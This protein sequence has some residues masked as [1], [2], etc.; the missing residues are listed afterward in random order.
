MSV[1]WLTPL[2]LPAPVLSLLP[3]A[4]GG[5]WAGGM[6]GVA[7]CEND[8]WTAHI[9]G[10][11]ISGVAALAAAG[12]WLFAGGG[13]GIARSADGGLTWQPGVIHGVS[14]SISAIAV[15][16]DFDRDSSVL[17]ATLAG[18]VLRS[19]DAG[20]SWTAANFGLS[21]TE[22]TALLWPQTDL[23]LAAAAH[24][25]YRSPNGGR[26]WRQTAGTEGQAVAA[27]A[28]LR[29]GRF[30]AA[31]EGGALLVSQDGADWAA[32][33]NDL[34]A[35]IEPAA[36]CV[37][38]DG[39]LLLGAL[40]AGIFRSDDDGTGWTQVHAEGVFSLAESAGRVYAGTGTDLL[41]SDDG[42]W[43]FAAQPRPPL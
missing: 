28:R 22:I 5:L 10:L 12:K 16:P 14:A 35:G 42:G 25:I 38:P 43:H 3:Q 37:L 41:A 40:D 34:P 32:L 31:V 9:A 33:P 36:L 13:E 18:G 15:S 6:G 27:L 2:T 23:V 19:E 1:D 4:N 30:L 21:D 24:G 29:D 20:Q 11:P 26:A 7:A 39:S 8:Q 17:A